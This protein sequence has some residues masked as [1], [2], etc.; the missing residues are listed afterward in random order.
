MGLNVLCEVCVCPREPVLYRGPHADQWLA[1]PEEGA[2][3]LRLGVGQRS[4]RR[5]DHV[6]TMRQRAG[7]P[8]LGLG[9]LPGGTR[10]IPG[11]PRVD[12]HDREASRGQRD[13]GGTLQPPSSFQDNQRGL[14]GL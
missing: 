6:G 3:F 11:L 5:A 10:D 4:G 14:D 12:H 13:R 7:I 8:R 9:E 2:Q 1:A